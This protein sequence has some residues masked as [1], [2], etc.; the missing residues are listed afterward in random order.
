MLPNALA[1]GGPMMWL[2]LLAGAAGIAVFVERFLYCH[3][4]QINTAEFLN[5][6]RTVFKRDNVLEAV[7]ICEAT[8]GPVARLVRTA[9]LNRDQGRERLRETLA[10]TGQGEVARLEQRLDLLATLARLAPLLGL[11]GTVLGFMSVF[12][13]VEAAGLNAQINALSAG[14]WRALTCTAAGLAVAIPLQAGHNYLVNRV[15][16]IVSEMERVATEALHMVTEGNG[17]RSA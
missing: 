11:L 9:I 4:A 3:R 14:I 10:V 1:H 6:V 15:G 7:S 8:P 17:T 2:I 12:Q 5:G 16:A 13:Q